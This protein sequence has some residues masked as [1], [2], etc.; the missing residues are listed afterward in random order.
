MLLVSLAFAFVPA[1]P[2]APSAKEL[3]DRELRQLRTAQQ[4]DGS[5]GTRIDT[6]HLLIGMA[7]CPRAYRED[8]GPFISD[9]VRWL[10]AETPAYEDPAGDLASALAF[11]CL[12]ASRYSKT[13]TKWLGD[14]GMDAATLKAMA[15]GGDYQLAK[16]D[17]DW[18]RGLPLPPTGQ[19]SV[20]ILSAI[21]EE[22]GVPIRATEIARAGLAYKREKNASTTE[23]D[24]RAIYQN[25]VDFL[26]NQR[27][28]SGMWEMFGQPEPGLSALAAKALFGSNRST[29]HKIAYKVLD[30]LKSIQKE[31]GSIDNGNLP[32]YVTS[33]AVMALAAG[34]REEDKETIEKAAQ[35]L[36]LMQADEGEG[37]SEA[38][39]FYGGIGYGNDLRP[40]LSNLQYA[41][42]ALHDAGRS[43]EDPA[44]Q[45]TLI[46]LQRAQNRSESN[47]EVYKDKGSDRPIRAGNDGGAVYYPGNSPAGY[48]RLAD[49]T[50]VARSY[51]SMTYALLKC[52]IFAGLDKEDPRVQ[53]ALDWVQRHWTLEV[54]PGFDT[55][56]DPRAGFQGLYYYYLTLAESLSTVGLKKVKTPSGSE[57]DWRRELIEHLAGV[58]LQDGSWVNEGASRWWEGNPVLCTSY[59][60]NA[61]QAAQN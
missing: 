7:L 30:Y 10:L 11:Q 55:L 45:R 58:Q 48:I 6:A 35:F 33:V 13:I 26:L 14:H 18:R 61:I 52:Y 22:A 5:Y 3:F 23:V 25:G 20:A 46:F 4:A 41:L 1:T 49:G 50:E 9:A 57:H 24:A 28:S 54:N 37:Y 16:D 21:P 19:S 53:A 32:V 42:Q 44:M 2:Q 31:S 60:L 51:G 27:G 17:P 56:R 59:A 40:D 15:N 8:D 38:D 12:D 39:K 43:K 36:I 47:P 29:D 34:G